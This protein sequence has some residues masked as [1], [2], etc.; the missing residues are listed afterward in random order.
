[1]SAKNGKQHEKERN[2]GRLRNVD[3]SLHAVAEKPRRES[4][5]ERAALFPRAAQRQND[6]RKIRPQTEHAPVEQELDIFA[7]RGIENGVRDMMGMI[8]EDNLNLGATLMNAD[9]IASL[10]SGASREAAE[11]NNITNIEFTQNNTSPKP[12]SEYEIYR[13]TERALDRVALR[14]R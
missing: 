5:G 10:L 1:M 6:P 7:V 2:T 4:E 12:L 13:N 9:N 11:I 14:N 8:P 3:E